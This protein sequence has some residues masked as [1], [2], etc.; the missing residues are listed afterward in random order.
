M[1]TARGVIRLEN[2]HDL[3]VRL[4]HSPSGAVRLVCGQRPR[5]KPRRD[6][7]LRT[8]TTGP[9]L[10]GNGDQLSAE[11]E[12]TCPPT[13]MLDCPLSDTDRLADLL[14]QRLVERLRQTQAR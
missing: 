12:T 13:G 9:R 11:R 14:K 6:P 3:P 2:L 7:S 4:L 1:R 5:D 8:D 10:N